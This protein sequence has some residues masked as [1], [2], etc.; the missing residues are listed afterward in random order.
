[1]KLFKKL[2]R[3]PAMK[4]EIDEELRFH[5]E[6]RAAENIAAGM[7][8]GDAEREARKRFGNVQSVREDCWEKRGVS[9]GE[10]TLRD[11]RFAMRQ[12]LKNPGF[13]IMAVLTLSLGIG[14]SSTVFS[15]I[16]RGIVDA[17]AVPRTRSGWCL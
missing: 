4:R 7:T 14:A 2:F 15:L 16:Q 8:K 5:L 17:A 9:F 10:D 12:L 3:Q 6:Q 11:L 1:M 13:A